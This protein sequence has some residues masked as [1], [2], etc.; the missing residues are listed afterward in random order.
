MLVTESCNKHICPAFLEDVLH[1]TKAAD[2]STLAFRD[3]DA[4]M[5]RSIHDCLPVWQRIAAVA[6][7]DRAQEVLKWIEHTCKVDVHEFLAPFKGDYKGQSYR[8]DLPPHCLFQNSIPC[9]PFVKFISRI[10]ID[11]LASGAISV[12]GRVD[13]VEPP[14]LVMPLTVEPTK[15]R[16]CND[17]CFLNLWI[18]HC[19]FN[20]DSIMSLPRYVLPS[21]FQSVCDDKS[22]YDHVL[23][24][25]SS[26]TFLGFQWAGWYFVSNTIPFG[27]KSSA[28]IY[29]S[30][31][32][33]ASHYFRSVSIPSSLYIDDHHTGDLRLRNRAPAYAHLASDHEQCFALASSA[34]FV[35]CFTLVSLGYYINLAKSFLVPCQLVPYLGFLVDSCKQAFPSP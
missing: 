26:R 6:P 24:S 1:G 10:I 33:L 4:F 9:K 28:F 8:S 16:L 17:N 30:I 12:W 23:L 13:E 14:H 18:K 29:H 11:R 19:P 27:W 15:P 21:P 3:P 20:L 2:V 25:P 35:V 5:A 7:Y 22:G 34:S 32:L 31:G